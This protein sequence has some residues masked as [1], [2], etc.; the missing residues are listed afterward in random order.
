MYVTSP[1]LSG[2][3]Q[4][5]GPLQ[6]SLQPSTITETE[7]FDSPVGGRRN[8]NIYRVG[9]AKNALDIPSQHNSENA[10]IVLWIQEAQAIVESATGLN[11]SDTDVSM[12]FTN[13]AAEG[14]DT[15]EL[16]ESDIK[17]IKTVHD[18]D[19]VG[20]MKEIVFN[21]DPTQTCYK[22]YRAN[23]RAYI[24]RVDGLFFRRGVGRVAQVDAVRGLHAGSAL[25]HMVRSVM[26]MIVIELAKGIGSTSPSGF[27][28]NPTFLRLVRMCTSQ[29][30]N[31]S[32]V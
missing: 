7:D 18:I 29:T 31:V 20:G 19:N 5:P 11:L 3:A 23:G 14:V 32:A 8:C 15:L 2:M 4:A 24:Q 16:S 12:F 26:N 30:A 10:N 25:A 28:E 9:D 6:Y 1:I 27:A 22:R 13:I 17:S 21:S